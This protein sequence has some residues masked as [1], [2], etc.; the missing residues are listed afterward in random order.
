MRARDSRRRRQPYRPA[1]S[2]A[3]QR[4]APPNRRRVA[5]TVRPR[6]SPGSRLR[7]LLTRL[8]YLLSFLVSAVPCH[9]DS[10]SNL[11][12]CAPS[13]ASS[14]PN[15]LR[16]TLVEQEN[17]S[18]KAPVG[19]EILHR[20][21]I[22]LLVRKQANYPPATERRRGPAYGHGRAAHLLILRAKGDVPNGTDSYLGG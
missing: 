12:T 13:A 19:V 10:A 15:H 11:L 21:G 1:H 3:R 18:V 17:S 2:I 5:A 20:Q 16:L 4:S 8:S 22:V 6:E 9:A 14:F 7:V